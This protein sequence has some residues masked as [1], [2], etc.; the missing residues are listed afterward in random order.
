[1]G[2]KA[3][4]FGYKR[5]GVPGGVVA[6]GAAVLGYLGAKRALK[7]AVAR[8][9]VPPTVDAERID[10]PVGEGSAVDEGGDVDEG[11]PDA[12]DETPAGE[13]SGDETET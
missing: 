8:N 3:A 7:S 6:G 13:R 10:I 11:R 5:Y 4:K 2:K 9:D 1:M 12:G